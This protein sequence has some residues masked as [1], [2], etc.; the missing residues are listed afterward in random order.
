MTLSQQPAAGQAAPRSRAPDTQ[1][2]AH[3]RRGHV[4]GRHD[5][6]RR[7]GHRHRRP[8]DLHRHVERERR[9]LSRRLRTSAAC[10]PAR[11]SVTV[12]GR[13]LQQ[14]TALVTVGAGHTVGQNLTWRAADMR[15]DVTPRQA[16]ITAG[17]AAI[18]L[19]LTITNTTRS[20]AATPC[21]CSVP[22][23]AGSSS[24]RDRSRCSPNEIARHC[25]RSSP[26]RTGIPAGSPAHRR[27]GAR[28]DARRTRAPSP[29]SISPCRPRRRCSC[30]S[31]RWR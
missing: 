30:A 18:L 16:E 7:D 1:L 3:H 25:A 28:A 21:G 12:D 14:Q 29:R 20:S 10:S 2:G 23:P 26:R 13:G 17:P 8:A 11:Y 6:R 9:L 27:P 15:V 4:H 22:T 24:R 31:T 19:T 5:L